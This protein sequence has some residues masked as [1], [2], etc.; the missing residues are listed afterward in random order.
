MIF[1][2]TEGLKDTSEFTK[3]CFLWEVMIMSKNIASV[4]VNELVSGMIIAKE[5]RRNGTALLKEGS[6]IN[7]DIIDR[8][9]STY[10]LDKLQVYI[11]TDV[12]EKNTKEA[13]IKKVEQAFEEV[14]SELKNLYSTIDN[15]KEDTIEEL[16][17]FAWKIQKQFKNNELIIYSVLFQGSGDD[18]IYRHGVNVAAISAL[19]GKWVGFSSEKINHLIY[20]ALLHDFGITRLPEE[21]QKK[22]D[23]ELEKNFEEV[24]EHVR[25]GYQDI[26]SLAC[27]NKSVICGVLMHHER[28]DGSGY[29]LKLNSEKIH[30]FAKIIAI[31]DEIDVLNSNK[32]LR[33]EKGAFYVL[34]EIKEKSLTLLDYQYT[35][36]FLEHISNFY[37]GEEVV[38]N[39]GEV[40]KILQMNVDDIESPLLLK[41]GEFINLKTDKNFRIKELIVK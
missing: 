7:E 16:R 25:I 15:L 32:E 18:C 28:C 38:L 21:L 5:V 23:L 12:I 27:L 30:P 37:I 40:A 22:P 10:F 24:K 39:N 20:S 2:N 4:G 35:K 17:E 14:S 8:L 33:E 6:I 31:A 19:I 3:R 29:P 1:Y 13:E 41:D 9:K 34:K 11:S 36:I 26:E